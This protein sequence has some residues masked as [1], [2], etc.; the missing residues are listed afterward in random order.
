MTATIR[1]WNHCTALSGALAARLA[2][3]LAACLAVGL[4]LVPHAARGDA[5]TVKLIQLLIQKGILSP[6]QAKDLL[7]ETA[8]P[9]RPARA[10]L[11]PE[12]AEPPA[13]PGNQIRV[14]Y[15]PQFIRKQ[16]ADEVRSEVMAEAQEE[17]WAAPDALPD[18][19]RRVKLTGDVRFRYL[20]DMFDNNNGNQFINF[21]SINNGSAFDANSY[22]SGGSQTNPPF[23]NTTQNR[24]RF[25]LRARIGAEVELDSWVTAGIKIGTGQDDG[26]VGTNQTLGNVNSAL[27]ASGDFGK[28]SIYLSQGFIELRPLSR[29]KITLG[30]FADPVPS[31]LMFYPD[32]S[33]DGAVAQYKQPITPDITLSGTVGGFP[34][35][36]TSFDFSTNSE[37]KF[38]SHDSYLAVIQAGV[39]WKIRPELDAR[40]A[41]GLFDFLG[42]SGAVSAPCSI[43][44]GNAFY[45]STDATRTPFEQFGNTL[46]PIRDIVPQGSVQNSLDPQYYGLSG[47]YNVLNIQPRLDILT[48]DPINISLEGQFIKNLAFNRDAI[49]HHGPPLEGQGPVN[50]VTANGEF[51]GGDTGYMV[52]ATFGKIDAND[53]AKPW[54]RWQWQTS[55]S[56]RYLETDATLDA[57][58]DADFHEGGTNAQ[59]YVL[60]G[61]LGLAHNT[62]MQLRYISAQAI[63]G[64]H[65]GTDQIYVDLNTRF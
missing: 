48:Y 28:P 49:L 16:I 20:S 44:P 47:R 25:R 3:T 39:D 62:W 42:V 52:K 18:W 7:K 5:Q 11:L 30:R 12:G 64:P 35:F 13:V 51:L 33:F 63:A 46:F 34:L 27:G 10:P 4:V 58:A 43:Q 41:V 8:G 31:D 23:L 17:H 60:I 61:N 24:N 32:T 38:S 9:A 65:Y 57:L 54:E 50:N 59:G 22:N 19:T 14:T 37:Q 55:I 36:N 45:C 15:V 26:P 6:G 21:N 1:R 29:L 53:P 2:G 40:L 56:Y